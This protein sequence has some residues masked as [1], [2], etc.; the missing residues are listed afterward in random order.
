MALNF[1][2]LWI[3]LDSLWERKPDLLCKYNTSE[4]NMIKPKTDAATQSQWVSLVMLRIN[5]KFSISADWGGA[6]QHSEHKVAML[7]CSVLSI[8]IKVVRFKDSVVLPCPFKPPSF[9]HR[10]CK[11]HMFTD[12]QE[13]L[14]WNSYL[15]NA[16]NR[17]TIS[18][19]LRWKS[20]GI[21]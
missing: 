19:L 15:P 18:V 12:R 7:R 2:K 3:L 17:L 11:Q 10:S 20:L 16:L 21:A 6:H 1:C 13:T 9:P 4:R 5:Y 8:R 14:P